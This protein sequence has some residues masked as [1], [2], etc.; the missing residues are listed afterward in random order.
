MQLE[1]EEVAEGLRI[2]AEG[3]EQLKDHCERARAADAAPFADALYQVFCAVGALR[4]LLAAPPPSGGPDAL[5][6]VQQQAAITLKWLD[7]MSRKVDYFEAYFAE[8]IA[9]SERLSCSPGRVQWKSDGAADPLMQG[10]VAACVHHRR[11]LLRRHWR[12][13]FVSQRLASFEGRERPVLNMGTLVSLWRYG[14][15]MFGDCPDCGGNAYGYAI[16]GVIEAIRYGVCVDC[17]ARLRARSDRASF[18]ASLVP[19]LAES[20]TVLDAT[21]THP[22]G[23]THEELREVLLELGSLGLPP[24]GYASW[25]DGPWA[26]HKD[27][28]A[29]RIDAWVRSAGTPRRFG[30]RFQTR[31]LNGDEQAEAYDYVRRYAHRHAR[32]PELEHTGALGTPLLFPLTSDTP[33]LLVKEAALLRAS[34]PERRVRGLVDRW[35]KREDIQ[36]ELG[37]ILR[38]LEGPVESH[39]DA[40]TTYG[41]PCMSPAQVK[42]AFDSIDE[43]ALRSSLG[44]KPT[45]AIRISHRVRYVS[46]SL[47]PEMMNAPVEDAPMRVHQL[48]GRRGG[49]M[50]LAC[51]RRENGPPQWFGPVRTPQ[52][53]FGAIRKR[54]WIVE[55]DD[56]A[57]VDR[58]VLRNILAGK[59]QRGLE[60]IAIG[61]RSAP[62]PE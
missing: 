33:R 10:L 41:G 2:C 26:G 5:D 53:I 43:Q 24:A 40:A 15:A 44:L 36:A 22:P 42:Q 57:R 23:G 61:W 11:A 14:T 28:T 39:R 7:Y 16:G 60:D 52:E 38:W 1:R 8:L 25:V 46:E 34:F 27:P 55:P 45:A 9:L 49:E 17:G 51:L 19:T 20:G 35:L 47:L 4:A 21:V 62:R 59:P 13:P 12:T 56:M 48:R 54:G 37:D 50:W 30:A 58:R 3:S 32:L 18:F 29:A 31:H 6:P